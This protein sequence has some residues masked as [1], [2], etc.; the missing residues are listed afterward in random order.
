MS[1]GDRKFTFKQIDAAEH[2]LNRAIE[3]FIEHQDFICAITLAGAADGILGEIIR[4][5]GRDASIDDHIKGSRPQSPQLSEKQIRDEHLNLARNI[6]KHKRVPAH[7]ELSL[8]LETE[9]VYSL[10]RALDNAIRLGYSLTG[11]REQ[12]VHWVYANREDLIGPP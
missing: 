5:N 3:L 1:H 11:W 6:L 9:A 8:S 12:F 10:T 7:Q 4:D 2:Q